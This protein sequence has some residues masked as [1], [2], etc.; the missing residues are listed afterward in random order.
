MAASSERAAVGGWLRALVAAAV[1]YGIGLYLGFGLTLF[2][3]LPR[4]AVE[5]AAAFA[6]VFTTAYAAGRL[7]PRARF[8]AAVA[9]AGLACA[10]GQAVSL[11]LVGSMLGALAAIG[12]AAGW[13]INGELAGGLRRGL[14]IAGLAATV[15]AV[16]FVHVRHVDWPAEPDPL[17]PILRDALGSDAERIGAFYET[18]LGGFLDRELLWR[19]EA[20]E[21]VL[22]RLVERLALVPIADAPAAFFAMPPRN[23]P[24]AM[25]AGGEARA[26]AGFRSGS[27][28]GDGDHF[29]LVRDRAGHAFVWVKRNF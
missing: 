2:A 26:S 10:I 16:A 8:H 27:R 13:A 4:A 11:S 1:V 25:P 17:P 18:D 6:V 21:A 5:P 20:E 28:G 23:W 29:L 19:I 7:A 14:R 24:R 15:G 3:R 9:A 12:V 22:D